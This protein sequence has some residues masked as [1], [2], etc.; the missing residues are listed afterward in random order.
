ME[1]IPV[2]TGAGSGFFCL[3]IISDNFLTVLY[4]VCYKSC[5]TSCLWYARMQ[6]LYSSW[7]PLLSFYYLI[8]LSFYHSVVYFSLFLFFGSVDKSGVHRI[9]KMMDHKVVLFVCKFQVILCFSDYFLALSVMLK[10][11]SVVCCCVLTTEPWKY[12]ANGYTLWRGRCILLASVSLIFTSLAT[13]VHLIQSHAELCWRLETTNR[14]RKWSPVRDL[15][16]TM[17]WTAHVAVSYSGFP[18]F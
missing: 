8:F 5:T 17:I 16:S 1:W 2:M 3:S 15:F 13:L 9:K 10:I 18:H 7:F 11:Y 12:S 6:L 14:T 4:R